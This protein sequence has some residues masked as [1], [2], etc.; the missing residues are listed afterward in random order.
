MHGDGGITATMI[1]MTGM[2][3]GYAR[4]STNDQDPTA[5]RNALLALGV[6]VKQISVSHGLTGGNRARSGLRGAM[7]ACR[8]YACG[9]QAGPFTS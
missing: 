7:A 6:E 5:K 2:N 4:V 9:D 1:L 8:R 3:I